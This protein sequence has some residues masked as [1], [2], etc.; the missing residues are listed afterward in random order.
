MELYEVAEGRDPFQIQWYCKE[1]DPEVC[2][3]IQIPLRSTANKD[4]KEM[5][6][7]SSVNCGT[8][9]FMKL[10]LKGNQHLSRSFLLFVVKFSCVYKRVLLFTVQWKFYL[11]KPT[12]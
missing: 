9:G 5:K 7:V 3:H 10:I 4:T 2:G 12:S 11:L 6:S 8:S 1:S